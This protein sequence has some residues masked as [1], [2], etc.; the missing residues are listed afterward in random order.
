[1]TSTNSEN[2]FLDQ[3]FPTTLAESSF[4]ALPMLPL[5]YEEKPQNLH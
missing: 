2:L 1:L 4:L 5:S 3:C